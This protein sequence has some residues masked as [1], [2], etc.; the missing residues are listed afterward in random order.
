MA[1]TSCLVLTCK[2]NP[3]TLMQKHSVALCHKREIMSFSEHG[4]EMV[5]WETTQQPGK[6]WAASGGKEQGPLPDRPCL[7]SFLP[8]LPNLWWQGESWELMP[9]QGPFWSSETDRKPSCL[10]IFMLLGIDH[11]S[12]EERLN[13]V[14][15]RKWV[16]SRPSLQSSHWPRIPRSLRTFL[17]IKKFFSH[18]FVQGKR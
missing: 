2:S 12:V 7:E 17:L 8:S 6:D 18:L 3:R 5:P 14:S 13:E 10:L 15:M 4:I 9:V 1:S 11:N 16:C